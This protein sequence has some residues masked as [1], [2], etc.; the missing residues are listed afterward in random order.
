MTLRRAV[1][2]LVFFAVAGAL[3]AG[4][5]RVPGLG[6]P[7][8]GADDPSPGTRLEAR[9]VRVIDGDTVRARI[10]GR[11]ETVRYI[12]IDTPETKKPSTP[13]Q[14]YGRAASARNHRLVAGRAVLLRTDAEARDRY[15]RLLAYVYRRG[16]GTFVN[17]ALVRDGFARTLTIAP[18]VAHAAE[19]LRLSRAAR[20]AGRGLWSACR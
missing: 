17:A 12:G 2:W 6:D 7:G 4:L 18:N 16:D 3:G 11:V 9:V 14:C 8:R 15:G 13:V 20:A 19:L 5:V 10:G 1:P